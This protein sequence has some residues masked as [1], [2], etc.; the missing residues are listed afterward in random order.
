LK[1]ATSILVRCDAAATAVTYSLEAVMSPP[2]Q[3]D[4]ICEYVK[5]ILESAL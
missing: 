4:G 2:F 1:R 5:L 3:H